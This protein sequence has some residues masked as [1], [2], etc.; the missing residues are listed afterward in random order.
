[1]DIIVGCK[2]PTELTRSGGSSAGGLITG[3][4]SSPLA[5]LSSSMAP[6]ASHG[7]SEADSMVS[8]LRSRHACLIKTVT[9]ALK[10]D[11]AYPPFESK[12]LDGM[13]LKAISG[14]AEGVLLL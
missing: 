4:V 11:D 7:S 8:L 10:H 12:F 14:L 6:C 5:D 2:S 3:G 1:M 9:K 13:P